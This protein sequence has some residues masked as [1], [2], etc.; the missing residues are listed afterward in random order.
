MWEAFKPFMDGTTKI[1]FFGRL[2][3]AANRQIAG[4]ENA[5]HADDLLDA[6]LHEG[7]A[8][9]DELEDGSFRY[10]DVA[11]GNTI[12]DDLIEDAER[13]GYLTVDE[14]TQWFSD[15]GLS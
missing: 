6:V 8:I 12:Y 7:F 10:L 15:R 14:T 9:A 13:Q 5:E 1:E 11:L 4:S 2:A 3:N